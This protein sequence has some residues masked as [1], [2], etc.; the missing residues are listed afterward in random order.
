MATAAG[1]PRLAD[2]RTWLRMQPDPTEDVVIDQ[3]RM[4]AVDYG[5]NR[6]SGRWPADTDEWL[7]DAVWQ[8]ARMDAGRIYRRRDSLDGTVAWG[9][10]GAV[11]VGRTDPDV[12][13]LYALYAPLVFG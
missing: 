11:R 7:P 3:A 6:M 8:A 4:A 5:V 9:D 10:M 2:V 1:W 12:E 13:R